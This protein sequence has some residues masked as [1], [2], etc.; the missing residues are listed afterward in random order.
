MAK[1]RIVH[2]GR[3]ASGGWKVSNV[4]S[5]GRKGQI[6]SG[7]A[8]RVLVF[9]FEAPVPMSRSRRTNQCICHV[10]SPRGELVRLVI[11]ALKWSNSTYKSGLSERENAP[12]GSKHG[13]KVE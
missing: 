7:D 1:K 2:V 5:A 10:S 3:D 8:V 12:P 11:G 4:G 6:S 13:P 9:A